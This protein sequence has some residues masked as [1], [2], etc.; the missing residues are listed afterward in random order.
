MWKMFKLTHLLRQSNADTCLKI[1]VRICKV[2]ISKKSGLIQDRPNRNKDKPMTNIECLFFEVIINLY[3]QVNLKFTIGGNNL[4]EFDLKTD[5]GLVSSKYLFTIFYLIFSSK[6][7]VG[8]GSK[9]WG[10]IYYLTFIFVGTTRNFGI[11]NSLST[12]YEPGPGL[13]PI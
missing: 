3:D 12:W 13:S 2:I 4:W 11:L 6:Y 9:S 8:V 10:I 7:V 5:C 1:R